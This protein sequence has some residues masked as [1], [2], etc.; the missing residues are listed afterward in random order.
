MARNC[1]SLDSFIFKPFGGAGTFNYRVCFKI[2]MASNLL[3]G[4]KGIYFETINLIKN[5]GL[6]I[7]RRFHV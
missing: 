4:K 7:I 2:L 6:F 1:L 3:A 5:T